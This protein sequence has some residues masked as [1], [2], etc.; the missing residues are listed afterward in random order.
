MTPCQRVAAKFTP[1]AIVGPLR[2]CQALGLDSMPFRVL[3]AVVRWQ[4]AS[5]RQSQRELERILAVAK[6]GSL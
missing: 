1:Q 6:G 3:R 2:P 5:E 4:M